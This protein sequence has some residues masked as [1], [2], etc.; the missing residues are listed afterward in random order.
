MLA[1]YGFHFEQP[2]WLLSAV[3]AGPVV[4]LA[5]RGLRALG[6][7]RRAMAI[8]LRALV[9]LLLAFA[10]GRPTVTQTH[11]KL[12]LLTVIDRSLSIPPEYW[13]AATTQPARFHPV[14]TVT[15]YLDK[16]LA[17]KPAGDLLAVIDVA[18]KADITR[19][20]SSSADVPKR[21][22]TLVGDQTLLA[23]GLQLALA[24]APP[25]TR[26]RI[27]LISDGNETS[28]DARA[29]ARVAAA[30]HIPIDVLP[31]RYRYEN[32]VVFR[33]VVAPGRAR[34]GQTIPLRFVLT[35]T[36]QADG[37][38]MLSL[39]D[40]PVKLDPNG[41]D[42]TVPIHLKPGTNV[43]SVSL[44]VGTQGV[45]E[46][47]ATFI[48]NSPAD[49]KIKENNQASTV[50]FVAGPGH[51]LVVAGDAREAGPLTKALQEAKI[52]AR[53]MPVGE[54]PQRLTGL[55]DADAV[56]LVNTP[57]YALSMAQQEMLCRYVTDLGGGLLTVGGPEAYGAGGW[58][59]SP[60]ANILP[61]DMDPPQKKQMPK[62]AL[63]LIM[64][65]CEMPSG[66]FW[67]KEVAKLAVKS[68]SRQDLVGVLDYA[69][70]GGA[71]EH[72][73]FPLAMLG[74]KKACLAAIDQMPMGDMPD[75]QVPMQAAYKALKAA[76]AG[77]K[78]M[79]IISDSDPGPPTAA[80]LD[81]MIAE[82]ITCT[83]VAVYP[84]TP[85]DVDR[86]HAIA[87][88]TGGRFYNVK[89]ADEL[90]QIFI[91][92]AQVVRRPL[93]IEDPFLPKIVGG[94]SELLRGLRGVP[95]LDGRVLTGQKRGLNEILLLGPDDEPI[96]ATTQAGLGRVMTFTSS[97][98]SR[99]APK[100]IA[101][102][103]FN[104]FWE[105]AVRWVAKSPQASDCEAFADVQGHSVTLTVEAVQPG[106][107]FVQFADLSGKA[108]APDMSTQDLELRQIGPGQYRSTF[109][110]GQGGSYLVN[111]RYRREGEEGSKDSTVQT[112]VDVPFAPEY[113]DLTDN[114]ALLNEL[115]ETT[116]GR[117]LP[118][119]PAKADLFSR[120]GLAP[121][122]TSLPLTVPLLLAWVGLFL[123]DVGVRRIAID[124]RAIAHKLG[125]WLRLRE[126]KAESATLAALKQTRKRVQDRLAASGG[127]DA[128]AGKRFAAGKDAA[129]AMPETD[130][131]PP[132][133]KARPQAKPT[134]A[135]APGADKEEPQTHVS[136][137][138]D[139]KKRARDQR[140]EK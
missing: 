53:P 89:S 21:T 116:G 8:A 12:T 59:G 100:W 133:P 51:V 77:Q 121:P 57:N 16:A 40:K 75:F 96:L 95:Q 82:K 70:A 66:N 138:L 10:L 14:A 20:P 50:T 1:T 101:W 136:R 29:V 139:A 129:G 80:L 35:S 58:I 108:I 119:D 135:K 54:F 3:L 49:D 25:G 99:W 131:T 94:T 128:D 31:L 115:A 41:A 26:V 69:W 84:H 122:R 67:G 39:N 123:L 34:S 38:L 120:S 78:H 19:L 118:G 106:G 61:I 73:V 87:A 27:L 71:A 64:H 44:P 6:A 33:R 13:K 18:E 98:D 134:D 110:A 36:H 76:K 2:W 130:L 85:N 63:V 117:V 137:L 56:V 28:G 52:D 48:P 83:G 81:A 47:K 126:K 114:F 107:K 109:Q 55:L 113:E 42:V 30:N 105:Q 7:V 22:I 72:W 111:L 104:R 91:K 43:H 9:V 86:L 68:L 103:G 60:V 140:G 65:A 11:D 62:G 46:F 79:I 45:H 132:P 93:I 32:E 112:V 4:W 17:H 88:R 124:V 125:V 37:R 23:A 90:P 102:G 97:A 127:A 24:I 92:E 5:W 74:D 15:E